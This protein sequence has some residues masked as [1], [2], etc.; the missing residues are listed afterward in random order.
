VVCLSLT[1][2]GCKKR[3]E[4]PTAVER[5][6][7][8]DPELSQPTPPG[9]QAQAPHTIPFRPGDVVASKGK[10]VMVSKILN[11]ENSPEGG[12]VVHVSTY[13]E[14]FSSLQEA[15]AAVEARK[16]HLLIGHAPIDGADY[17]ESKYQLLRHES[18][19]DEEL[20]G[21]YEYLKQMGN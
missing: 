10:E 6:T 14:K 19:K 3:S 1:A 7:S 2:T 17:T 5:R 9:N 11:V 16:L 20:K 18:V 21:Y 15:K 12:I 4:E 13:R 8:P